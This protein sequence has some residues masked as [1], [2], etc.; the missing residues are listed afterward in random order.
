M[1]PTPTAAALLAVDTLTLAL[2]AALS[3]QTGL[4][5]GAFISALAAAATAQLAASQTGQ[6]DLPP[7]MYPSLSVLSR[8]HSL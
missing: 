3:S 4:T 7:R 6:T 1:A 2:R 8:Y 5:S